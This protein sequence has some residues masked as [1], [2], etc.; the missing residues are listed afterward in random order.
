MSCYVTNILLLPV[1]CWTTFTLIAFIAICAGVYW[2]LR[3][4]GKFAAFMMKQYQDQALHKR[5]Q[6]VLHPEDD[7]LPGSM[8]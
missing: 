2:L 6:E 1:V 4:V 7:P 8:P 5:L 3:G